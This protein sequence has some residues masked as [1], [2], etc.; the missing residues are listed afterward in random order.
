MK[1]LLDK[2]GKMRYNTKHQERKRGTN[3]KAVIMTEARIKRATE[4]YNN[5]M[6]FIAREHLTIGT[7]FSEDTEGW[8]LK[9]MVAEC[10][11]QLR[12][13]YESGHTNEEMRRGDEGERKAW[14]SETEKLKRFIFAYLPAINGMNCTAGHCSKYDNK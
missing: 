10:D 7:R 5:I 3:M 13:Y 8:N 9:D 6:T 4:R 1:M 2:R 14:V 11:Y 12:T